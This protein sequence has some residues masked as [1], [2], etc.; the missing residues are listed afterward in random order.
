MSLAYGTGIFFIIAGA[1]LQQ[2]AIYRRTLSSVT[3]KCNDSKATLLLYYSTGISCEIVGMFL[4]TFYT[5]LLT[6]TFHILF[7]TYYN[8]KTPPTMIYKIASGVLL[9]AF[10]ISLFVTNPQHLTPEIHSK[11]EYMLFVII[12]SLIS[13]FFSR[14]VRN[15]IAKIIMCS[16]FGTTITLGLKEI[17]VMVN[18]T[19]DGIYPSIID[20]II[21]FGVLIIGSFIQCGMTKLLL[22]KYR[23]HKVFAGYYL[24]NTL[25]SF[26]AAQVIFEEALN[27]FKVCFVSIG[28]VVV[29]ALMIC[30]DEYAERGKLIQEI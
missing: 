24:L 10:G 1:A 7:F 25:T 3:R 9:S 26:I 30:S 17:S 29:G 27:E 6:S 16:G 15:K 4:V 18:G 21:V 20:I 5:Y 12:A 2:F 11:T 28:L 8:Y 13:C 23:Q 22:E 19:L 14:F